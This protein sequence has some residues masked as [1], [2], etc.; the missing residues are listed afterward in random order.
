MQFSL[1]G[2]KPG[3]PFIEHPHPSMSQRPGGLPEE[4]DVPDHQVRSGRYCPGCA[5]GQLP[6]HL[7]AAGP[8]RPIQDHANRQTST[9]RTCSSCTGTRHWPT[10]SPESSSR[11]HPSFKE[12]I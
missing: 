4:V 10:S 2:Y 8:A 11:N 7:L 6:R 1:N 3:D 5:D 9:S 12:Q